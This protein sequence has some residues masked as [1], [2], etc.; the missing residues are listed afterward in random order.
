MRAFQ[1]MDIKLADRIQKSG[2]E[3]SRSNAVAQKN[4]KP[5]PSARILEVAR[6]LFCR[7]GIHATGIDKVL[8][9]AKVSKMT[10]YS[11]FGSKEALVRAVLEREGTEWRQRLFAAL[12][13]PGAPLARLKGIIPALRDWLE[14]GHFYGCAFMNAIGEH[15]KDE[16]WLRD[17]AAAHHREILA[18]FSTLAE[19]AGYTAP[20]L[21]A[22]QLL[23]LMDGAIAAL[24]VSGKPDALDVA[25]L[26]LE[27]ILN[28]S[29]RRRD[30]STLS[31]HE[32]AAD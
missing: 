19:Q 31:S 13:R 10:L 7:D 5:P 6:E 9:E 2:K 25:E 32:W 15:R 14:T 23:L 12:D 28:T 16:A 3:A 24:M 1:Q 8:A 26:N 27:A 29:P 17:M 21:L 4:T 11:R 18:R 22:K 20:S 30:H